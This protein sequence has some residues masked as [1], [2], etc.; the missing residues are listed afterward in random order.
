[1]SKG[2]KTRTCSEPTC[3]QVFQGRSDRLYCS[4]ACASKTRRRRRIEINQI[5]EFDLTYQQRD[6]IAELTRQGVMARE[7]SRRVKISEEMLRAWRDAH[8][9]ECE[10]LPEVMIYEDLF[11]I[12]CEECE[13]E[14]FMWVLSESRDQMHLYCPD[15]QHN[16]DLTHPRLNFSKS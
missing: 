11:Q 12:Y 14:T 13:L 4:E 5:A 3:G 6:Q 7:I 2:I 10:D 9:V 16:Q 1:M 15:C 8:P